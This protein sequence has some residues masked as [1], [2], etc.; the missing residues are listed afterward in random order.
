M[1]EFSTQYFLSHKLI[2]SS[3]YSI[4]MV[5]YQSNFPVYT[6]TTECNRKRARERE[7]EKNHSKNL[8]KH[9]QNEILIDI[10]LLL[11]SVNLLRHES[12]F[13]F[14][15]IV[16]TFCG[17]FF[18]LLFKKKFSAHI[19]CIIVFVWLD[20]LFFVLFFEILNRINCEITNLDI[21]FHCRTHIFSFLERKTLFFLIFLFCFVSSP[22]FY[23]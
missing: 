6:S 13:F 19:I 10:Q 11:F 18:V 2:I 4:F 15:L 7:N 12:N 1:S 22:F 9:C 8:Y 17:S 16:M 5:I 20:V 14:A 3:Q 23:S 21:L